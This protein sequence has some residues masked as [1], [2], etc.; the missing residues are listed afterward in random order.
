MIRWFHLLLLSLCIL[1]CFTTCTLEEGSNNAYTMEYNCGE[2]QVTMFHLDG[3]RHIF[4]GKDQLNTVFVSDTA[5]HLQTSYQSYNRAFR[6]DLIFF[7]NDSMTQCSG[8][9]AEANLVEAYLEGEKVRNRFYPLDCGASST[10][11]L[12]SFDPVA[13]RACGNFSFTARLG[14]YS[15][16]ITNGYFDL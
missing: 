15:Y 4:A 6:L 10:F 2:N 3:E 7:T 8:V 16:T 13:Q 14:H 12:R 11:N 5:V 1:A 9:K